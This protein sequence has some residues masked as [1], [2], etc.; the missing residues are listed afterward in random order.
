[1]YILTKLII[2][3]VLFEVMYFSMHPSVQYLEF[4][5][6]SLAMKN[7]FTLKKDVYLF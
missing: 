4:V 5:T 7:I 6:F 2:T 3:F 1:M